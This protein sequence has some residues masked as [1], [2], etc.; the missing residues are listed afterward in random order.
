MKIPEW[1]KEGLKER[2]KSKDL[3]HFLK[4]K[5]ITTIC[6]EAQCPNIGKC[7]RKKT[8]T[9]LIM[10]SVC[11]RNCRFC[12]VKSGIPE[13]LDKNE[14]ERIAEMVRVLAIKHCV[15]TSVTRDDL[16]DGGAEHFVKVIEA[17]RGKNPGVSIEV[18][19]PDFKGDNDALDRII[20][21]KPE[22][23]NHNI[24][25][26]KRLYNAVRPQAN[27]ERSLSLLARV[28]EQSDEIVV[29]SGMMVGL[30]EKENEVYKAMDDLI[31]AGVQLFTIGQYLR[32]TRLHHTINR[33]V[34]P[35]EFTRYKE[36]GLMKGFLGV[37]SGP[38]VRSS[39]EAKK[40]YEEVKRKNK[41]MSYIN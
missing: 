10:G 19:I 40:L 38:F 25:T 30:G 26:I 36:T 5:G 16:K 41:Q 8:A 4:S 35:A 23:I 20:E 17:V 7:F 33:Y 11:T 13:P 9:F 39:Y 1:I 12:A 14:P 15:I 32:P 2:G 24:E 22:V 31:K 6:E 27:Y 21:V 37:A 34:T 29:K 18:L 3:L 28:K